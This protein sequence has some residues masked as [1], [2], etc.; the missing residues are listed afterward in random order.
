MDPQI[1]K[2]PDQAPALGGSAASSVDPSRP[3]QDMAVPR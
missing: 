3:W 2:T 1:E